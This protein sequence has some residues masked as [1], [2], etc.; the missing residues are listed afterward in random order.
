MKFKLFILPLIAVSLT[1][2]SKTKELKKNAFYFDTYTETRLFEG[3]EEDLKEIDRIFSKIDKLTDN[4]SSRDVHN[5]FTVNSTNEEVQIDADLY[6]ILSQSFSSNLDELKYFN[7][8]CGSLSKKWKNSLEIP[9]ILS[10]YTISEELENMQNTSLQFLGENTVKR[11]GK[12]EIDLGAVAKGFA[13]DKIKNYLSENNIKK[14][15]IDAGSSSLLLGEKN[16]GE[17]FRVK[18]SNLDSSYLEVK[19]CFIST[20]SLDRQKV[21]I[22]GKVYSHII[23]PIDGS[24]INK[25]D[26]VIVLSDSGYLGDILSTALINETVENIEILEKKFNV[27]TLVIKDKNIVYKNENIEVVKKWKKN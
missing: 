2:C 1:S 12:S 25:H 17:N 8:L 11:I 18:L 26:A 13:L 23:N 27:Q 15:L 19:N 20:S 9:E 14:Y 22:D 4:F 3:N 6:E 10:N 21:E 7:P 16:N 24:A 5:L